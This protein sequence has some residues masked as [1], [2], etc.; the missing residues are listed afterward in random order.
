MQKYHI[1]LSE[2]F[3]FLVVTFSEY[4]NRHVFVMKVL[5]TI[6]PELT[7][8]H[9][10]YELVFLTYHKLATRPIVA[11]GFYKRTVKV[12]IRLGIC[13]PYMP[14]DTFSNGEAQILTW[15]YIATI[16]TK[17]ITVELQWLE[18]RWLVYHG[19]VEHVLVRRDFLQI[20]YTDI[21]GRFILR[22]YVVMTH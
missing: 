6:I 9:C 11:Y 16:F 2:N 1:F 10:Q 12:L 19:W 7:S 8:T 14:E 15:P 3:H 20:R 4:L 22:M 21:L 13:F 5:R 17:I 18:P